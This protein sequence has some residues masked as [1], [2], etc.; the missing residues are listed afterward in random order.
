MY[1]LRMKKIP[2][3]FFS[4]FALPFSS[5][6]C[7]SSEMKETVLPFYINEME[8]T[9]LKLPEKLEKNESNN[10]SNIVSNA[11]SN[12]QE[13]KIFLTDTFDYLLGH[14]KKFTPKFIEGLVQ[15]GNKALNAIYHNQMGSFS[16]KLEYFSGDLSTYSN[17]W[18]KNGLHYGYGL[19]ELNKLNANEKYIKEREEFIQNRNAQLETLICS[20]RASTDSALKKKQA[21]SRGAFTIT[22]RDKK[23][24]RYIEK[25]ACYAAEAESI[26]ELPEAI[27]N[28]F[29]SNIAYARNKTSSH[30][31]GCSKY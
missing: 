4:F 15:K 1:V 20:V 11:P 30:Y 17:R 7:H 3:V 27:L 26:E 14:H 23:L 24:S 19:E 13:S 21:F 9:Q 22:D 28:V 25:F 5:F 2:L 10:E 18:F 12:N 16:H 29:G 6:G 31:V 8:L